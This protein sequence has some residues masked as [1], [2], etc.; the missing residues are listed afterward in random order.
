MLATIKDRRRLLQRIEAWSGDETQITSLQTG[1][2]R[3]VYEKRSSG[4]DT[5]RL[6]ERRG[7]DGSETLLLD[8]NSRAVGGTR[9]AIDYLQLSPDGAYV[10][11]GVSVEGSEETEMRILDT[12]TGKALP[13]RIDRAQYASPAWLPDGR[14]FFYNRLARTSP[15]AP[16]Q[17]K[18]L[19]SKALW[20][21]LGDDPEHDTVV[22][23]M[24]TTPEV[25]IAPVDAPVLST[26]SDSDYVLAVNY[27]GAALDETVYVKPLKETI[28]A[29]HGTHGARSRMSMTRLLR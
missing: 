5:P 17:S 15:A 20:H 18:Y 2:N 10:V 28:R 25:P 11:V 26:S 27:H 13:E 12:T 9:R 29:G 8:P 4:D 6:Y 7:V 3:I 1:G 22:L 23:A 14:S 21:K 16:G 19:N 24:G